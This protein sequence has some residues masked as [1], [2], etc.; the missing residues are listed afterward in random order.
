MLLTMENFFQSCEQD[1]TLLLYYS[2]HGKLDIFNAFFLCASDTR[3]DRLIATAIRDDQVN[4][5]M[6]TSPARS[7]VLVLDCCSSGPGRGRRSSC[8]NRSRGRDASITSSRRPERQDAASGRIEPV[9]AHLVEAITE[10]EVDRTT[11]GTSTSTRSTATS[12]GV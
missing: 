4:A 9:H 1:D 10:A 2:G 6:H 8:P 11:M 12:S 3:L 7:F 5:M